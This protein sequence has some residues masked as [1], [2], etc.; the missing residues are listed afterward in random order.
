MKEYFELGQILKPQ[1]L[2]GE[3][4]VSLFTDDAERI[5]SLDHIFFKESGGYVRA[6][7]VSGRIDGSGNTFLMLEDCRDRSSAEGLRGCYFYI[8][9]EHAAAIP[10]GSFYI[11]DLIG[12][13]VTDSSGRELGTLCDIRQ[14]GCTD[15][16][17][18]RADNSFMFPAVGDVFIRRDP[19]SGIIMLDERRLEEIAV[20]DI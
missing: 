17:C 19:E 7:V 20:Y 1:G 16:Y 13:K 4:K 14:N 5:K 3:V 18:V 8:D 15:V 9:R 6:G 12:L 11:D 2:K 10:E